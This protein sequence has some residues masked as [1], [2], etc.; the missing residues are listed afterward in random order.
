MKLSVMIIWPALIN[1]VSNDFSYYD[2]NG[3]V[4]ILGTFLSPF[5]NTNEQANIRMNGSVCQND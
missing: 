4:I 5:V 1:G 3:Q 2:Q